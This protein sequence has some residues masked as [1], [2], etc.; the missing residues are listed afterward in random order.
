MS[1]QQP[2]PQTL[3]VPPCL[4]QGYLYER[5]GGNYQLLLDTLFYTIQ[6]FLYELADD[7][8]TRS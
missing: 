1:G 6:L 3:S 2:Y 5:E 7:F 4:G 8:F